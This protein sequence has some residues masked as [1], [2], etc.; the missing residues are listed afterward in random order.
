MKTSDSI[1][2]ISA[3][4][5]KAQGEMSNP[6][7]NREVSVRM[8]N[9]DTYKFKYAT[10]D[11]VLD[12]V[13]KPL[14]DAGIALIQT[15]DHVTVPTE[16][17]TDPET[18]N[19]S[20]MPTGPA[21]WLATR[22]MCAGEYIETSIPVIPESGGMQALGS[23]ITYLRRYAITALLGLAAEED[24]DANSQ[25]GNTATQTESQPRGGNQGQG[26]AASAPSSKTTSSATSS[27]PT[28][29]SQK[30]TERPTA[31]VTGALTDSRPVTTDRPLANESAT[32]DQ[33]KVDDERVAADF[34]AITEL[35]G[36][37]AATCVWNAYKRPAQRTQ[38]LARLPILRASLAE[39]MRVLGD[40]RG[41]EM[42]TETVRS[43][44]ADKMGPQAVRMMC[45]CFAASAEGMAYEI[46][47]ADEID[48][49]EAKA[50]AV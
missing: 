38:R 24:D 10:L 43:F 42:V 17:V 18:G 47:S 31:T 4:L 25:A 44:G 32:I 33:M 20:Q 23:A 30:S 27:A 40:G 5:A 16:T 6:A 49:V 28:T 11:G 35:I 26:K 2:K 41:G 13:R 29:T 36:K 9:G 21:L 50:A 48:R 37:P 12:V 34:K 39:V 3:A 8:K 46:P 1:E 15:V 45:E 7:K 14:A 19:K 22:L